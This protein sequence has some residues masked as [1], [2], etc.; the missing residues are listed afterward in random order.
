MD[1]PLEGVQAEAVRSL[2]AQPITQVYMRPKTAFWEQ[3]GYSPS[4]FT[5][6]PAGM[7]AAVRGGEDPNEITTMTAWIMGPNAARLDA[8]DAAAAGR[9]VIAAIENVRPAA[10][11]QLELVGSKAWGSDPYAAGAWAYFRPGEIQRFAAAMGQPH[12]RIHF[13]G[14]HLA[15]TSRGMEGAMESGELAA[16]EILGGMS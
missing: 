14:E 13:C 10:R 6:S 7:I 12:G 11:G 5:D 3:D 16:D 9:E 15:R 2:P 8:L 4:L 1:P